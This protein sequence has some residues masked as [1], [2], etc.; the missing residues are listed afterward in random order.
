MTFFLAYTIIIVP[1]SLYT[2]W[3]IRDVIEIRLQ[4]NATPDPIK[5]TKLERE[6]RRTRSVTRDGITYAEE[7]YHLDRQN[8]V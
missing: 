6:R 5:T 4:S 2:G 1:A 8:V 3:L 7:V